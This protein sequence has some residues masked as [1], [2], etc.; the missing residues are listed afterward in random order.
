MADDSYLDDGDSLLTQAEPAGS[1]LAE[2]P[3]EAASS[4]AALPGRN[5]ASTSAAKLSSTG[6]PDSSGRAT[7]PPANCP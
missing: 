2:E 7:L 3:A 6:S 1:P 5:R 4:A